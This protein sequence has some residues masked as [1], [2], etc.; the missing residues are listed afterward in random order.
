M[1]YFPLNQGAAGT[2]VIAAAVPGMRHKVLSLVISLANDGTWRLVGGVTS[3]TGNVKQD[4]QLQPVVIGPATIAF[5][6]TG[7]GE[8]L[9][10]VT[11]QAAQGVIGVQTEP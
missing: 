1:N 8:A 2:T 9:S 11:T 5:A 3:L 7:I 4:G 6:E 10:I